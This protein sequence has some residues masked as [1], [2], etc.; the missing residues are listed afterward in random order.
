MSSVYNVSTKYEIRLHF[1]LTNDVGCPR[2][3]RHRSED[4]PSSENNGGC[5][6][7]CRVDNY[8][9]RALA[10]DKLAPS[11]MDASDRLECL[12]NTRQNVLSDIIEW[13]TTPG[14][15]IFW[16]RGPAGAGKSTLPTTIARYF[17]DLRRLGA[18]VFLIVPARI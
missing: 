6:F 13:A 5:L 16:L 15:N 14:K 4:K 7:F 10:L 17:A 2:P 9:A 1:V 3:N 12:V 11:V 8:L 18:F